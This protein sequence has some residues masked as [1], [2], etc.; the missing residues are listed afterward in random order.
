ML[1]LNLFLSVTLVSATGTGTGSTLPSYPLS[2][3]VWGSA[4]GNLGRTGLSTATGPTLFP[5]EPTSFDYRGGRS[6]RVG[7]APSYAGGPTYIVSETCDTYPGTCNFTVS[8]GYA[9]YSTDGSYSGEGSYGET[10]NM[11]V[12]PLDRPYLHPPTQTFTPYSTTHTPAAQHWP[13]VSQGR[14]SCYKIALYTVFRA[15]QGGTG[16]LAPLSQ[17]PTPRQ[18][19]FGLLTAGSSWFSSP[20]CPSLWRWMRKHWLRLGHPHHPFLTSIQKITAF[21]SAGGRSL[22]QLLWMKCMEACTPPQPPIQ[23]T[24]CFSP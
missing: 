4:R 6:A 10:G 22:R 14:W 16:I 2:N 24:F 19:R 15:V 3:P 18:R 20:T 7:S 5:A 8:N 1:L 13:S 23:H 12:N 17:T 11:F 21:V 9:I